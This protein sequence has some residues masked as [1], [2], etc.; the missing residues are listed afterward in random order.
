MTMIYI[1]RRQEF[2]HPLSPES[3]SP[4]LPHSHRDSHLTSVSARKRLYL[5][6]RLKHS[7]RP[8]ITGVGH[9]RARSGKAGH[10]HSWKKKGPVGLAGFHKNLRQ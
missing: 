10:D 6:G 7:F 8:D 2:L 5:A 1:L 3:H 9:N 4:Q